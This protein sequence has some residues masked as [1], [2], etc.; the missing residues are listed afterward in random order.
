MQGLTRKLGIA[1]EFGKRVMLIAGGTAL[2][3]ALII[4]ASPLLTR[5]YTPEDFGVLAVYLAFVGIL[6][7]IVCLRYELA[8]PLPV[9]RRAAAN[10]LVLALSIGLAMSMLLGIATSLAGRPLLSSLGLSTFQPYLWL[11][12]LGLVGVGSYQALS[13]WAIRRRSFRHIARTRISQAIGQVGIQLGWG[14]GPNG[15][16][17]LMLGALVGQAAGISTLGREAWRTD[18]SSFRAVRLRGLGRML[19]RYRRFAIFGT[20]SALL[21]SAVRQLPALLLA[22]M[23]GPQFAGWY[24]LSQRV[25]GMPMLLLGSA[26][27]QVYFG[28][29]ARLARQDPV[30]LRHLFLRLSARLLIVGVAALGVLVVAGP[31]LFGLVFGEQWRQ[32]GLITQLLVMNYLGQ[33][34]VGTTSQTLYILERQDLH[35]FWDIFQI[36]VILS[37]FLSATLL[38]WPPLLL[39]A[40]YSFSMLLAYVVVFVL[41]LRLIGRNAQAAPPLSNDLHDRS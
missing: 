8:I 41:V 27:A 19:R 16:L 35:L 18:R 17:G 14:M 23:Y 11:L 1:G 40:C 3:R 33:F 22:A 34:V 13:Y 29:A 31:Q 28:E 37:I 9:G 2:G 4:L 39:I 38:D 21:N 7:S 5:L 24:A 6:G 12:P 10:V 15:P 36:T 25:I 30:A 20:G 26:V 32:S